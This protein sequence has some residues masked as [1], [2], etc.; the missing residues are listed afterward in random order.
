MTS[1]ASPG[2]ARPLI[3]GTD[4][5]RDRAGEGFLRLSSVERIVAA[6][7]SVLGERERFREDF[8]PGRGGTV[9]VARDTRQSGGALLGSIARA[10]AG[11]GH[12]VVD[13]GV[14]PTPGAAWIAAAWPEATLGVV[15]S[16]SHNPAEYN[17]VKFVAP[18]GAKISPEFEQAVS[19]CYWKQGS[20][21]FFSRPAEVRDRAREARE[22][23]IERLVKACRRPD[24]LAGRTVALDT[25][26][27]A[28][29]AI[30]PEVFRRLRMRVEAIG[31]R[32]DGKN[33]NLDCGAL[34]PAR[35]S[36]LVTR[37][38]APVGFC[39][40][41][42]ADRMIPVTGKGT[43][44][45]GDHVLCLAGR[46]YVRSGWLP[47]KTVVA[48]SMSNIGLELA[49]DA[50]GLRLLRTDVGDRN[51]Y[52]AMVEGGH[53]IGGEQSGHII[54]LDDA[55]TGDGVLAA[56]RLLDVLEDDALD[57]E[58]EASVMKR[59]PQLLRNVRVKEKVPL[60]T[61]PAVREA[62]AAAE[63]RLAGQGRIVLRYSGTEPLAR[64]ML[65]GP[66]PRTVETL[67][68]LICD[69]IRRSVPGSV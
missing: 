26:N 32:P 8:P 38:G 33:I 62:V 46:N 39:F 17:G 60:E 53:P 9:V 16:A 57:L 1:E 36:D 35:L 14:L 19:D 6:T 31:D 37:V 55:R 5:V 42:D 51:V 21:R 61:L 52:L 44:L 54:F 7:V 10:F 49:L 23:Y 56:L 45:D 41:G 48:T 34:H 12:V 11:L 58:T 29:Y 3:F 59:Y 67:T 25:A 15:I 28:A 69:A 68:N 66:D 63:A 50:V 27:G 2:D 18:T 64:V 30:A 20:P 65:E 22:Q 13:L 40:D 47:R 4:G 43:V 24:R